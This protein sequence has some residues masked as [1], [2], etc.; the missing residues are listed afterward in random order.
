MT[1]AAH[2]ELHHFTKHSLLRVQTKDAPTGEMTW[3]SH[4]STLTAKVRTGHAVQWENVENIG[5]KPENIF[6]HCKVPKNTF[7]SPG[8]AASA[9]PCTTT[10]QGNSGHTGSHPAH[11]HIAN[12]HTPFRGDFKRPSSCMEPIKFASNTVGLHTQKHPTNLAKEGASEIAYMRYSSTVSC[13]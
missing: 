7:E 4:C 10:A 2:S 6:P 11:L 9:S 13:S 1:K 5:K 8:N 3:Q 12:F